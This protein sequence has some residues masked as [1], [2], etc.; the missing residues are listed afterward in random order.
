MDIKKKFSKDNVSIYKAQLIIEE[1]EEVKINTHSDTFGLTKEDSIKELIKNT[2]TIED[3]IHLMS[4]EIDKIIGCPES[5]VKKELVDKLEY[6]NKSDVIKVKAKKLKIAV[7]EIII[8]NPSYFLINCELEDVCKDGLILLSLKE[9]EESNS[10]Y[11]MKATD[12]SS[13]SFDLKI[14]ESGAEFKNLKIN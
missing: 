1:G 9:Y 14:D 7:I 6:E 5:K 8:D 3:W 4:S 11:S 13:I 10:T 2:L 12:E